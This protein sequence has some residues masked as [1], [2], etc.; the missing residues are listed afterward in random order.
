VIVRR[1]GN[2]EALEPFHSAV[3]AHGWER[4]REWPQR[5]A[6]PRVPREVPGGSAFRLTDTIYPE[7]LRDQVRFANRLGR[8]L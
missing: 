4:A 1:G 6:T 7:P 5:A 3:S 8:A 2:R